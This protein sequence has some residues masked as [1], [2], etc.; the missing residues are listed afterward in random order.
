MRTTLSRSRMR[1]RSDLKRQMR[2]LPGRMQK[3]LHMRMQSPQLWRS[4]PRHSTRQA[5]PQSGAMPTA[6][7]AQGVRTQYGGLWYLINILAELGWVEDGAYALDGWAKLAGLAKAMLVDAEP[8]PI[9]ELL[10]AQT[11]EEASPQAMAAWL[12]TARPAVQEHI[13]ERLEEQGVFTE[14]LHD[15]ATIYVTRTHVDVAFSI[16]QIRLEFRAAGLDRDPGW[17]PELGRVV[18]F[19]YE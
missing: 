11:A 2:I 4:A 14:A 3:R 8:D 19:H 12:N 9:W 13:S 18:A 10:A 7:A 17:V 5:T 16:E 6:Y 15:P 1:L